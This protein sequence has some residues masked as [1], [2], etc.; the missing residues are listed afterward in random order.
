MVS[1]FGCGIY[2]AHYSLPAYSGDQN[3]IKRNKNKNKNVHIYIYA[4]SSEA[5]VLLVLAG[6]T[7][8]RTTTAYCDIIL[9]RELSVFNSSIVLEEVTERC[10][11]QA[12][13]SHTS[14]APLSK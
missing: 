1:Y 4:Q 3:K 10:L 2:M 8:G 11:A 14:S 6:R 9:T 5:G 13:S 7:T 12:C